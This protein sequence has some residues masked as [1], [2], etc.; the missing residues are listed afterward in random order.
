VT[1]LLTLVLPLVALG[2]ILAG[3][4]R[5]GGFSLRMTMG[6]GLLI[7]L[8]ILMVVTRSAVSDNWELWPLSY[9]PVVVALLVSLVLIY[10]SARPKR[11]ARSQMVSP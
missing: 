9:L 6:V 7:A 8:Q 5:R 3:S 2:S 1:P 4:F 10:L 11:A